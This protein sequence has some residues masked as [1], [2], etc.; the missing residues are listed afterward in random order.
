MGLN[1]AT[2]VY[3][4]IF[5]K[6]KNKIAGGG[7]ENSCLECIYIYKAHKFMKDKKNIIRK[8]LQDSLTTEERNELHESEEALSFMK[9]QWQNSTGVSEEKEINEDE[10]LHKIQRRIRMKYSHRSYLFYKTISIAA[11]LLLIVTIGYLFYYQSGQLSTTPSLTYVVNTGQQNTKLVSLPDGSVVRMGPQSTLTYP[12]AFTGPER[13]VK[14]SGQA[15][16]EVAQNKEQP[17]QVQTGHMNVTALGTAFEIFNYDTRDEAETV[18][19][20]GKVKI[21]VFPG[22]KK[23][24]KNIF[25]SPNQKLSISRQNK[26]AVVEPVDANRYLA[27]H[28]DGVIYFEQ[29]TLKNILPRL[30]Q[31]YGRKIT[32]QGKSPE[33]FRFTFRIR[34]ESL[35]NILYMMSQSSKITYKNV[36]ETYVLKLE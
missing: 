21:D 2:T 13:T 28:K 36:D 8:L 10:V 33:Q 16:F 30:E 22:D 29:E 31:W 15:F 35:E 5:H 27:W 18:L 7:G 14:L 26:N 4:D 25:L 20:N 3:P 19:L 1:P 23:F 9:R 32:Y 24:E 17:F 34:D 11:S 6:L 12:Q